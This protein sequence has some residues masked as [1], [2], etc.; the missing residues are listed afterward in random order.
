MKLIHFVIKGRAVWAGALAL[1]VG[2]WLGL[3]ESMP[4]GVLLIGL[5]ALAFVACLV[6]RLLLAT[7][8]HNMNRSEANEIAAGAP[9]NI[10]L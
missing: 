6:G 3:R 1:A 5:G 9:R 8:L 7:H 2:I 4:Q 10:S